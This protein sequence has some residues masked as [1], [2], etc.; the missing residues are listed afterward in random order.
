MPDYGAGEAPPRGAYGALP[1]PGAHYQI[2]SG[3]S[4]TSVVDA[5]RGC[6]EF[7]GRPD[8]SI[9]TEAIEEITALRER[10]ALYEK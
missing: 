9:L 3:A 10:L 7:D 4:K 8:E 6:I 1:P 5:L 2:G